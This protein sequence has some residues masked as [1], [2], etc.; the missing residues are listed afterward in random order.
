MGGAASLPTT[1]A[2]ARQFPALRL[3]IDHVPFQDWDKDPA[4]MRGPF[5]EIARQPNI[6]AKISNVVRRVDGKIIDDPAHYRP[7]LDVLL[8]LFGPDRVVFG[9]NWPVSDRIAPYA[10]LHRV[11]AEYFASKGPADRGK[12]FLAQLPRRLPLAPPRRRGLAHAVKILLCG[13]LAVAALRGADSP[14]RDGRAH[15]GRQP[16]PRRGR[17]R[18]QA[19]RRRRRDQRLSRAPAASTPSTKSGNSIRARGRGARSRNFPGRAFTAARRPSRAACGSPAATSCTRTASAAPTT[20]VETYDPKTGARARAPDLPVALPRPLALAAAGR[21]WV[22]G[23]RDRTERGQFASIGAGETAWRVEPEALPK[24]WAL[25]GA[26]LGE[27]LYICV[28]D[29]GLAEFDPAARAWRVIPGPT[30]PRSGQVAAWRGEIWIMGGVDIAD[31][32]A[33][34]IFSSATGAWRAGPPLPNPL[35]WGAAGVVEDQLIVTGGAWL[36]DTAEPRRYTFTDRT[37]ALRADAIPP[38]TGSGTGRRQ[39]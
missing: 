8:D 10:T 9:S 14:W 17:H 22:V 16:R 27:K 29:T 21:L 34:W 4:A 7:A 37:L 33:T 20:L 30:Q 38:A 28:P 19:L 13:L 23:A 32:T 15:A 18:G 5:A 11:V 1:L 36:K 26:V 3:V 39:K 31:R 2:L 35:A 12:I 25:A 24:M 6:F